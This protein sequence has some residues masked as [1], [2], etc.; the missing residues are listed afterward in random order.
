MSRF[1]KRTLSFL[2]L[3][4]EDSPDIDVNDYS[5]KDIH[6]A[7]DGYDD[8]QDETRK[9][10]DPRVGSS[11][12][13]DESSRRNLGSLR[14]SRKLLSLEKLKDSKKS[15]VAIAEPHE[16]EEVQM[17]G[18]DFKENIPVIINLQNTNQ[19]LSKRIIDF[20]SGLTYALGGSIRKV[21]DRVFLITPQNTLVTSNEKEILREKGLYNQL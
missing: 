4:E 20:C 8:Y 13:K 11:F 7:K 3:A 1:F 5:Q 14:T 9:K 21:A 17:I 2:G 18:D 16:F 12:Y 19:D 10:E 15:R 6:L